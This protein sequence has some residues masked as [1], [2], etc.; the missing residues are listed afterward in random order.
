MSFYGLDGFDE[1]EKEFQAYIQQASPEKTS[2]IIKAGAEEFVRDLK[3]MPKPR[4]KIGGSHTHLLDVFAMKKDGDGWLVGWGVYYGKFVER[5]TR[6]MSARPH[7]VPF[8]EQNK[9]K[10]HQTMQNKFLEVR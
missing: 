3:A 6:K 2:E 1:L 4:S 5:G 10:Y 7:M 8:W 9:D